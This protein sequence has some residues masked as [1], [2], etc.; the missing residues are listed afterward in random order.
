[1]D[2]F[3]SIKSAD[4]QI[5]FT[6]SDSIIHKIID[7]L[8]SRPLT[9]LKDYFSSYSR[10]VRNAVKTVVVDINAPY[11][12]LVKE[13]FPKAKLIVDCFHLSQLI[14]RSLFQ[15]R[16]QLMNRFKTSSPESQKA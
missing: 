4:S 10:T 12:V 1:M 6:F 9:A 13:L 16:I 11:Y 5:S 8:P 7:I 15:I 3:K 2:E 14:V